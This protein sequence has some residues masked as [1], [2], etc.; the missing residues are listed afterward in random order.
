MMADDDHPGKWNDV[1]CQET[2]NAFLCQIPL[3]K[4]RE[5][6]HTYSST[7]KVTFLAAQIMEVLHCYC[8]LSD[9]IVLFCLN[10]IKL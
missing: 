1:E 4:L 5:I 10:E 6:Q 2:L 7:L 3:G 8:A 9:V